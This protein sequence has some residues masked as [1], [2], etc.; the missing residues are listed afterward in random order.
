MHT[1]VADRDE[2][3][4]RPDAD[5]RDALTRSERGAL[6]RSVAAA[7][8]AGDVTFTGYVE[9]PE[10]I[11]G[12]FDVFALSS[13]TEQ[14]PLSILEAMAAGLAVATTDAGDIRHMLSAGNQAFV[15]PKSAPALAAALTKLL[16]AP[17]AR[18]TIGAANRAKAIKDFDG[19][20]ILN[21]YR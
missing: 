13:D 17:D 3:D 14:M 21:S 9:H 1:A 8:L 2:H 20:V 11:L 18:A 16:D 7:G 6:E 10:R 19:A 12:A 5:E 4:A 15:V